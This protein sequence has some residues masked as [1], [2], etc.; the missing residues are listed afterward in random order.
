MVAQD[1]LGVDGVERQFQLIDRDAVGRQ[2]DRALDAILPVLPGF[3]DHARDQIDVDVGESR[4]LDPLPATVDLGRQMGPAVFLQDLVAEVLHAQAQTRDAQLAQRVHL[5]FGQRPRFTFKGDL[6]GLVPVDVAPQPVDERR[7]LFGAEEGGRAAA[8]IDE[9]KRAIAHAGQLTQQLDLARQR[10]QVGFDLSRH[11]VRVHPEIAELAAL[12]AERNVQVQTQRHVARWRVQCLQ[13]H[14]NLFVRPLGE[15]RIVRDEVTADFGFR[16]FSGHC[17]R[18]SKAKDKAIVVGNHE[19]LGGHGGR[20]GEAA[21]RFVL[22]ERLASL[23]IQGVQATVGR[24]DEDSL[25]DND[26]RRIDSLFRR[27][28]P[29]HLTGRGSKRPDLSAATPDDDR[30]LGHRR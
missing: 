7:E 16:G 6:F 12:A 3:A 25:P 2:I 4:L 5:R 24:G 10:C 9:A 22:P 8:E 11:L 13:G 19:P 1:V 30:R 23:Q 18:L 29:E 15:R 14:G 26:R 28:G 20:A 17:L 21:A 27:E